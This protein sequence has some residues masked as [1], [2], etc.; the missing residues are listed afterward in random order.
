MEDKLISFETAKLAKEKD[1]DW[2][3]DYYYDEDSNLVKALYYEMDIDNKSI[4]NDS[5]FYTSKPICTAPTQSLLQKWLREKHQFFISVKHK[6]TGDLNNPFV[7][8]TYNGNR[9]EWNGI[10]YPTYE[11]ALEQALVECLNR[12]KSK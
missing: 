10:F 1:F 12:L 9:G 7:E 8:Y 6:I 2:E 3:C 5:G 4:D 11:E